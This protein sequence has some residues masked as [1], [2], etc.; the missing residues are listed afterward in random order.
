MSRTP[1]GSL[2]LMSSRSKISNFFFNFYLCLQARADLEKHI[3]LSPLRFPPKEEQAWR[4]VGED[5]TYDGSFFVS[6]I[7]RHRHDFTGATS[8][9]PET[10]TGAAADE[11]E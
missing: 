2:I 8:R 7:H 6:H 4:A 1:A 3:V 10:S 9:E 11:A 5:C